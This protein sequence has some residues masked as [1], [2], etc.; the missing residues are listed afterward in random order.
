[1]PGTQHLSQK[2][3]TYRPLPT[4]RISLA[5]LGLFRKK[6]HCTAVREHFICLPL[7][8]R[9]LR[10]TRT[11][12]CRIPAHLYWLRCRGNY[13][14]YRS[15]LGCTSRWGWWHVRTQDIRT[16]YRRDRA[17]ETS[18]ARKPHGTC[19]KGPRAYFSPHRKQQPSRLTAQFQPIW[20]KV[21]LNFIF[22]RLQ[23]P[24]DLSSCGYLFLTRFSFR[25]AP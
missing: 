16:V 14:A 20:P 15:V 4:T 23:M 5:A 17:R 13:W 8:L 3:S 12:V 6:T 2:Y 24:I 7:R 9:L 1:M 25:A 21:R 22:T 18:E 10:F 19:P 11:S